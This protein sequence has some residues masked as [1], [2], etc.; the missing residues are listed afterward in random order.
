ME[1]NFSDIVKQFP[2]LMVKLNDSDFV[3][4]DTLK[5]EK[6][7]Y[8]FYENK[9]PVYV[10]RTRNLKRRL[11]EHEKQYSTHYSAT[12]ALKMAKIDAKNLGINLQLSS[13]DLVKNSQFLQLFND[14]KDRISNMKIKTIQI[15]DPVEQTL[16]EVYAALELKTSYNEWE[17]H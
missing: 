17:T 4:R 16:F 3:Q 10:G 12:L 1:R 11:Q 6:G 7:V 5:N 15:T 9:K 8:V 2:Q 13:K 14:A